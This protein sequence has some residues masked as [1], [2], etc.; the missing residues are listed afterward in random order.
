MESIVHGSYRVF[1]SHKAREQRGLIVDRKDG[2]EIEHS[3]IPVTFVLI[4][5]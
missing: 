5:I 3:L 1:L 4:K 2:K